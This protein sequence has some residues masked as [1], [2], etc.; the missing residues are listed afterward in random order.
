MDNNEGYYQPVTFPEDNRPNDTAQRDVK[1][2]NIVFLIMVVLPQ[3]LV[4]LGVSK[5]LR[6][7]Y[8]AL[9]IFSQAVYIVPV[10]VWLIFFK[11]SAEPCRFK[12]I[13]ISNI[14]LCLVIYICMI[15]LLGLLNAISMLYSTNEIGGVIGGLSE[16]IPY[17]LALIVVA[18]VPAFCEE[19]TYRGVFLSTYRK[20]NPL[21]AVIMSGAL[22]GI[23][24][25]NLNQITYAVVLGIVFSLIVEATDS[26]F[27]SMIVHCM[28]NAFSTTMVYLIPKLLN[29][30]KELFEEASAAG[31]SQTMDMVR[32]IMGSEDASLDSILSESSNLTGRVVLST[33]M[34]YLLPAAVGCFLAFMLL[35]FIARRNGRWEHLCGIFKNHE[36]KGKIFT[37]ALIAALAI[38]VFIIVMNELAARG[39]FNIYGN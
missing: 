8:T 11:R 9:L 18:I 4:E 10:L 32:Q 34:V 5:L 19:L 2:V 33:V 7:S 39:V 20:I 36:K 29:Y 31:D 14:F 13:R 12:K 35:R 27:S 37:W 30:L 1:A 3:I 26:I 22:F 21:L 24:H 16:Q 15:P 28:I 17:P 23:L 38:L 25:G 6:G